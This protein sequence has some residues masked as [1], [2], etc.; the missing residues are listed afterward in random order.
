[1][2]VEELQR[3]LAK[4]DP[5]AEVW[6]LTEKEFQEDVDYSEGANCITSRVSLVDDDAPDAVASLRS[7]Q[8]AG[9]A[10]DRLKFATFPILITE[11]NK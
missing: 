1:M 4:C 6:V 10:S 8:R 11:P 3:E 7:R 2:T 9:L 5:K